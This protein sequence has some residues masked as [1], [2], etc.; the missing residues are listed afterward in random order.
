MK[1]IHAV[2][3]DVD[4]FNNGNYDTSNWSDLTNGDYVVHCL[5]NVDNEEIIV[6]E[7]NIHQSVEVL[8]AAFIDG[9]IYANSTNVGG[10]MVQTSDIEV[11]K[12]FIVVDNGLSHDPEAALL[13][14]VEGAYREVND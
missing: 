11:T 1:F 2:I 3:F 14:L 13:C 12:A 8:I 10:L 7:D 9:V 4:E 6:L 5:Y